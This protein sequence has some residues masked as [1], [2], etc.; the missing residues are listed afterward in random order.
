MNTRRTSSKE[1]CLRLVRGNPFKNLE[2][3]AP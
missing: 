2:K 3:E 1:G